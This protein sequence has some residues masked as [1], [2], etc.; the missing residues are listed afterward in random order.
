MELSSHF[1][2]LQH[3][4]YSIETE[5]GPPRQS[6]L[7][8]VKVG[9]MLSEKY[10]PLYERLRAKESF[11][12]KTYSAGEGGFSASVDETEVIVD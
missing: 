1:T 9:R 11:L 3:L 5:Y 8:L 12:I 7:A 4:K 10:E 2:I 6:A